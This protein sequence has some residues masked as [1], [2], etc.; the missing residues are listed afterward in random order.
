MEVNCLH[1]DLEMMAMLFAAAIHDA[2]HTG[3]TND[4]HVSIRSP[5]AILYND[6]SVLENHHLATTWEILK[7]ENIF[8]P[9]ESD[10][11]DYIRSLVTGK[12]DMSIKN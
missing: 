10:E 8:E 5:L 6:Q 9:L 3:T 4:F 2:E 7:Q 11:K 12:E 1:L